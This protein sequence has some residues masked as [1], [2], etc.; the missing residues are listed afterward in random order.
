MD[1][2]TPAEVASRWIDK[3][4]VPGVPSG[5]SDGFDLD[6]ELPHDNPRLCLDSILQVLSRIPSDPADRHFQVLAAGPLEDLLVHHGPRFVD[7]IDT[8]AR[9][10]PSFRMLLNGAWTSR[11]DQAVVEQ[12]AKYRGARW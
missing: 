3:W 9:R 1:T 12:L 11:V 8:L 10:S 5:E 2:P 6:W 4:A 7:E